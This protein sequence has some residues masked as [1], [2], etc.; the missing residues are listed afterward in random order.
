M[1]WRQAMKNKAV[2]G[3]II[4]LLILSIFSVNSFPI[5]KIDNENGSGFSDDLILSPSIAPPTAPVSSPRSSLGSSTLIESNSHGGSWVDSFKDEAGVDWDLSDNITIFANDAKL[6]QKPL[7]ETHTVAYWKFDEGTGTIAYDTTPNNNDGTLGGDGVGSDIPGWTT[8]KLGNALDFDGSDDYVLV[9]DSDSLDV[10]DGLIIETWIYP[11]AFYGNG[12][13]SGNPILAKWQTGLRSQYQLAAY[14]G[15]GIVF[16]VSS[17]SAADTIMVPNV[18]SANQWYKIYAVCNGEF[19]RLYLDGNLICEKTTTIKMLNQNE[20]ADDALYIGYDPGGSSPFWHFDGIIDELRISNMTRNPIITNG[21]LTSELITL[22]INTYW[23]SLIFNFTQPPNT[24]MNIT[25]LNGSDDQPLPPGS[26]YYVD[27]EFDISYIDPLKYP[28]IRLRASFTGNN[29]TTP[30]LHYWGVSWHAGNAW[31]DSLFGGLKG[32]AQNLTYGNGE[33]WLNTNFK[34]W[35]KYSVNPIITP[36]SSGWDSQAVLP[37][38][39]IFNGTCYLMFYRGRSSSTPHEIGMATSS[40]GVT[41]TKYSGNPVL[42]I[43]TSGWDNNYLKDPFVIYNGNYYQMWYAAMDTGLDR[44]IGYATSSDGMTWQKYPY[45]PVLDL[46]ATGAWDSH[47]VNQPCV[48]FDGSIYKMWYIGLGATGKYQLGYAN[49]REGVNWA[50]YPSN[51]IITSAIGSPAGYAG[52]CSNFAIAQN[53]GYVGWYDYGPGAGSRDIYH[54]TS[55]DG[56]SWV[57]YPNNPVLK[58]GAGSAWD[59]Y[60]TVL[61]KVIFVGKQYYMYY[62]G[63]DGTKSQI[64]L[65][66][67]KFD[68]S[69]TLESS[70]ITLPSNH[71]WDTL[72]FNQTVSTNTSLTLTIIDNSTNL[73]IMNYT[74][75]SSS[76]IDLTGL[77]PLTYPSIRLSAEFKSIDR[78]A[79]PILFDWSVNWTYGN[80]APIADAGMNQIVLESQK[81]TFNGT[82][83]YDPDGTIVNWSWDVDDDGVFELFGPVVNFTFNDD[84]IN[85]VT[86]KVIDDQGANDTDWVVITVLNVNSTIDNV[87]VSIA[88]QRTIGYWKHQC[89]IDIPKGD[90]TGIL[91]E[92]ITGVNA[93]SSVF[94]TLSSKY[95]IL[96]HL[97]PEDHSNMT[98]KAK[99]QLLALWLNVVSGKLGLNTLLNLTALTTAVTVGAAIIEIEQIILNSSSN[100]SELERAKD[101]ADKINNG[102]GTGKRTAL[103]VYLSDQG[104]DDINLTIDWRDGSVN[105]TIIFYNNAPLNTSDPYPS[106]FS[107]IAPVTIQIIPI[108]D[109]ISSGTYYITIR[110]QDDDGGTSIKMLNVII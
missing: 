23:D 73:P 19:L 12:L 24:F 22:P 109:Y 76:M 75:L 84:S 34:E 64:G 88:N 74:G 67:S 8:G 29:T 87:T 13:S 59:N 94:N 65:A 46:G 86:I 20:Y 30:K 57:D 96:D 21:N 3:L 26:S 2:S 55:T 70:V 82:G 28:S 91:A 106:Q 25:I 39:V 77:D 41:W 72:I 101:I 43:S 89:K 51:P 99:Q 33:L 7:L 78:K 108:H 100:R 9:S 15:G 63:S 85:N 60:Y 97:E 42:K 68:S 5:N 105:T 83:S 50:K 14:S 66:K 38:N 104:S 95:D 56:L 4:L 53:S 71:K 107:G 45:N 36:S 102:F 103:N 31:R 79:T 6:S 10:E 81:V 61:P 62:A 58:R 37:S 52:I 47:Y 27:G 11:H 48:I 98:Q 18:L 16:R 35:Y 110:V 17:G 69:G 44:R 90:H 80:V 32:T 92:Y 1:E 93:N 40:D 49:S 54:H